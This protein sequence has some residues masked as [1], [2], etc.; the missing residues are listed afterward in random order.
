MTHAVVCCAAVDE[1]GA[2]CHGIIR[3]V[4]QKRRCCLPQHAV[5]PKRDRGQV[6]MSA[7]GPVHRMPDN[8][9]NQGG[10]S[11]ADMPAGSMTPVSK[12]MLR[13]TI[14]AVLCTMHILT[15]VRCSGIVRRHMRLR[16]IVGERSMSMHWHES[17]RLPYTSPSRQVSDLTAL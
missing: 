9:V 3:F 7:S 13:Q 15:Q 10:S 2:G 17:N 16:T 11:G 12:P 6:L 4:M 5:S 14:S 8:V 1:G